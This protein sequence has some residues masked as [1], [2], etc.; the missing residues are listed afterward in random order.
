M[1]KDAEQRMALQRS[2]NYLFWALTW[3]DV[4]EKLP[5]AQKPLQPNGLEQVMPAVLPREDPFK[6]WLPSE[7]LEQFVEQSIT[8][9]PSNYKIQGQGNLELLMNFLVNPKEQFWQ[10]VA[11][12][13]SQSQLS[14]FQLSHQIILASI[15]KYALQAHIDSWKSSDDKCFGHAIEAA[16]GLTIINLG[17]IQR[18]KE[19]NPGASFRTIHF[20]PEPSND[21]PHQQAIWREW[22]R[23]ANLFQFLPHLIISTPGWSGA[24]QNSAINPY[25]VWIDESS[26]VQANGQTIPSNEAKEWQTIASLIAPAC[27]Q[28]FQ[29]IRNVSTTK[30]LPLPE[31]GYELEGSKGEVIAEAEL[32]W[33]DHQLAI[34]I[35]HEDVETF[36][37]AGWRCWLIDDSPDTIAQAIL[38]AL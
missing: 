2:G 14:N 8:S 28:V 6:K 29:S 37:Q 5:S 7:L 18:H 11:Q 38:D 3:D 36:T 9:L 1:A 22:I 4:V 30:N 33:P 35:E 25:D 19:Q 12:Q 16:Q 20:D 13:F 27:R 15:E 10:G 24:E 34:A 21:S 32:A 23:Q 31:A 26:I 17:D